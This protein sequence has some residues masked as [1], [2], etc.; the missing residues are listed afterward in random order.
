MNFPVSSYCTTLLFHS[1]HDERRKADVRS[2]VRDMRHGCG[3][4][5]R[6]L[7]DCLS[8]IKKKGL[9]ALSTV[10][11]LPFVGDGQDPSQLLVITSR[12]QSASEETEENEKSLKIVMFY[13]LVYF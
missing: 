12:H 11:S 7:R 3:A 4:R 5:N 2:F 9:L 10:G 1:C 6:A 8:K 13:S